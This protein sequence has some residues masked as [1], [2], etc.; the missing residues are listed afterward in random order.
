MPLQ[1]RS[2]ADFYQG[3]FSHLAAL[4]IDVKIHNTPNEVVD[5]IRFDQ[6]HQHAAYDAAYAKR[7]WQA[8]V[9]ADRVFKAFRAGFIGKC[10]PVH[11]FWGS[12]DLAVTRFS[13][14][15]AP[16]HPGGVPSCPDWVTREAY[17]HELSSCG[18]WPGYASPAARQKN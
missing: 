9:Q 5:G 2:V 11:F 12:F 4:G 18:F 1:P 8:L 15:L 17:S 13:G 3:L 14:R 10:S 6:D 7:F 16:Q